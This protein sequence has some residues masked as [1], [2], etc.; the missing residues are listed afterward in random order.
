MINQRWRGSSRAGFQ[1]S[2]MQVAKVNGVNV[3][4][5]VIGEHGP[6]AAL[7]TGGRR[8]H[9]EF[10]PLATKL[11]KEGYRVVLH[12]RRNTGRSD[13]L[14]EGD[15]PEE[16]LWLDDLH[17]LLK[18]LN[19][20]P[21]IIGGSS[22]GARTAMRYYNRFPQDTRALLLM[23]VTG[24]AFAASRL[25]EN[26][27][28][29]FI[30][31]AEQGGMAAVCATEQYQERIAANPKTRD[32]LMAMDPKQYIKVMSNWQDQFIASTKTEV[33]GMTDADLAAIKVPTVVIPGNDQT[34]A[35]VNGR[36]AASKIPGAVLHQLPIKDQ[37]IPLINYTEWA[38]Q[39]PEIARAFLDIMRK[40]DAQR[41]RGQAAAS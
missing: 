12:D 10:V 37:E 30:K 21:T 6:W 15:T 7:I 5:Q 31:A 8:G 1:G 33:F 20:V 40:A 35:S 9:D 3:S 4:Y 11:A 2:A 41:P 17:E 22:A 23:R 25:P 16:I 32:R 14:I 36:I 28:G 29:M 27:Y 26:Y 19:A 34:H 39:E 24:G 18:Q 38:P 13:V